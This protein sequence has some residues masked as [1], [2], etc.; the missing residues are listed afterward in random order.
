MKSKQGNKDKYLKELN[1][2]KD[3]LKKNLEELQVKV[4][5]LDLSH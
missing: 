3:I 4:K 2:N 5:N 1:D